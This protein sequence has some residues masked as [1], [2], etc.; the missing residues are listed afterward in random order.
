MS[1]VGVFDVGP[2]LKMIV[3]RNFMIGRRKN[4]AAGNKVLRGCSGEFL[5][6]RRLLRDRDITGRFD[7]FF[8]LLVVTTVL[9]IQNPSTRTR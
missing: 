5:F 4:D 7:E 2:P 3:Q 6:C 8:E 9:S 1:P